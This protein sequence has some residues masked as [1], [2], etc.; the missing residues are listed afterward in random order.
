MAHPL[1]DPN[2]KLVIA[3]R[4]DRA[5]A[6]ENTMEALVRAVELGADALEVDVRMT[7]DGVPVLMH[8]ANVDRTTS[9][10]GLV[11]ENTLAEL[12][13]LDASRAASG[14]A[15][16]KVTVPTLEEVLDRLRGTPFVIDVKELAVA[17]ATEQLIHKF[18]LQGSVVVGS[19][20]GDVSARL[21]R[22]G[23]RACASPL[24]AVALLGMSLVGLS[25]GGT[26]DYGVL[27]LTPNLKGIPIPVLRMTTS[28]RRA[29]IPT[30]VWT[31]NDPAEA[32][33]Y[34]HGGVSAIIT[35]DPAA[36]LRAKPR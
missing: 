8:D 11:R 18:G 26:P 12:R 13:L 36:I 24:D 2:A 33:K 16:G 15:G 28:A 30:H 7:R 22:S 17:A 31:V 35:D 19:D 20:N 9:G 21:Y 27:S 32:T 25:P 29:G 23:I 4:G 10:R 3:H 34:W 1:S 5:H 14:W 6:P